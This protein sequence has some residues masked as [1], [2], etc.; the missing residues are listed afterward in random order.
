CL[1]AAPNA[2]L[3]T[4][5]PRI[6]VEIGQQ[7]TLGIRPE[8]V[9]LDAEGPLHGT[10]EVIEHLGWRAYIH[11]RLVDQSRFVVE[12]SADVTVRA[13]DKLRFQIPG[14]MAHLFGGTGQ[15]LS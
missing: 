15:R 4:P 11:A 13:G 10:V 2:L 8:H 9:L 6:A 1:R 7:V 14:P 5:T 12:S 3:S